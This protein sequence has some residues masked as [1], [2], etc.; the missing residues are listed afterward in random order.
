M[1]H[2]KLQASQGDI[3]QAQVE[4]II[5]NC[6]EGVQSPGGGTGIVDQ[7][8]GGIISE[9]LKASSAFTGK[10]G[11]TLVLPTYGKIP[12][13]YVL[14][15]GLGKAEKLDAKALRRASAAAVKACKKLKIKTAA[16]LL[17]GAGLGGVDPQTAAHLLA[18]GLLLGHYEFIKRKTGKNA[19]GEVK[20]EPLAHAMESIT[21]FEHDHRKLPALETGLT[22][23][24]QV[25]Q[26]VCFARDLVYD[27]GNYVTPT[28]LAHTAESIARG[29]VSVQVYDE[30][31]LKQWGMGAFLSVTQGSVQPPKFI[32]LTYKPPS[33]KA[34]KTVAV[35][36]KGI[37]FDTGGISLK[38]TDWIELMKM[39][40]AGAA[41]VL[42]L[43][44]VLAHRNDCPVEVHGFIPTC[45][46]MPSGSA[47]KPGDI[48]TAMSGQTIEVNNTDAEGRLILCDALTYAQRTVKP[49]E[50][51]DLATL[52]GACIIA[53]GYAASGIMGTDNDLIK[54]LQS[55]GSAAGEKYWELP[56]YEEYETFLKSEV[57]D[58]KNSGNDRQAGSSAG[59]M[60]LKAFVEEGQKW[61]HLDIAGPA[62]TKLDTPETSKGASG[63]GVRTL[64]YYL[65]QLDGLFPS[66]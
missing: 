7:A 65:Y 15:V 21:V 9:E 41:A 60:F 1:D 5:I 58:L 18:E 49:D 55:A 57:A 64:L 51:I 38:T 39:D 24:E 36:G 54:G 37:T 45:E 20:D 6:F 66:S 16:T 12:A 4:A 19:K 53:L 2:V 29:P 44:F 34:S 13:R 32:H 46:N 35:V 43:F 59:G 42:G 31:Q 26:G 30:D 3:L 52:T 50:M 8:L 61:A 47:T 25:A 10:L 11:Q 28:V 33:G 40:M 48:V 23:G 27:S 63:V 17:H 62:Y 56:L 14:V 22:F